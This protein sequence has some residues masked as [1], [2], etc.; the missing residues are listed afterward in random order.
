MRTFPL[1]PESHR[2]GEGLGVR[3]RSLPYSST[4]RSSA[5]RKKINRSRVCCT[6]KLISSS[7]RLTFRSAIFCASTLRHLSRET[8]NSL[9]TVEV[10]FL[11]LSQNKFIKTAFQYFF[12]AEIVPDKIKLSEVILIGNIFYTAGACLVAALK[13]GLIKSCRVLVSL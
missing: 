11:L 12:F 7:F 9:S 10:P 8:K 1:S 2:D 13:K 6:V 3:V 4:P 5:M